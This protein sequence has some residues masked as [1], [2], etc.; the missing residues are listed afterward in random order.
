MPTR[1]LHFDLTGFNYLAAARYLERRQTSNA[2]VLWTYLFW[3]ILAVF[4]S[5][6]VAAAA[7]PLGLPVL[8]MEIGFA[9]FVIGSFCLNWLAQAQRWKRQSRAPAYVGPVRLVI[10]DEGVHTHTQTGRTTRF[11]HGLHG[12][13]PGP[14]GLMVLLAPEQFLPIPAAAFASPAEQAEVLA[15]LQS[16]IRAA[17]GASA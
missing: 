12:A 14:D 6:I 17:K 9:I 13:M 7:G 16:R 5:R 2:W 10:D 4:G 3:A 11:W 8:G 1:E 15:D